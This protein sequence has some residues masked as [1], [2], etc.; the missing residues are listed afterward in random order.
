M[1]SKSDH[2]SFKLFWIGD[3]ESMILWGV[4]NYLQKELLLYQLLKP[5]FSF[6]IPFYKLKWFERLDYEFCVLHLVSHNAN[7]N[8]TKCLDKKRYLSMMSPIFH[9]I[10]LWLEPKFPENKQIVPFLSSKF[11]S[12]VNYFSTLKLTSVMKNSYTKRW[13]PAVKFSYPLVHYSGWTN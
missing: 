13:P 12:E 2:N 3:P 8:C 5:K 6:K 10:Y 7:R 4:R 11:E 1:K 9:C